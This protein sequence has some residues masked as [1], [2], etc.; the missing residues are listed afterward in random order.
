MFRLARVLFAPLGALLLVLS[1]VLLVQPATAAA[2]PDVDIV[3]HRGASGVAPEN[4]LASIRLALKQGADVIENDIMRT[5]DDQ[6][7]IMHDISLARTTDV[8]Q[9]FPDRSPWNVSMFTLA[10]IKRLDAGS[11]FSPKL[12]E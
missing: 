7:V 4:T 11:W 6:L 3:G 9:V 5:S 12:Q 2:R 8:E 10:E 1:T